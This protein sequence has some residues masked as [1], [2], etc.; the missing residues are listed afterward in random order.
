MTILP[1]LRDDLARARP[2]LPELRDGLVTARRRRRRRPVPGD[3]AWPC[4]TLLATAGALAATGVIGIGDPV[5]PALRQPRS[6]RA[7][8]GVPSDGAARLLPLRV[9]DPDGGP[10]WGLRLAPTSRGMTCLQ[11]GRVVDERLGV[12]GSDGRFHRAPAAAAATGMAP[13]VPPDG[14]G[15]FFTAVD[16]TA[17]SGGALRAPSCF[18]RGE[19]PRGSAGPARPTSRATSR[20]ACSGLRP[21]RVSFADGSSQERRRATVPTCSLRRRGK[22]DAVVAMGGGPSREP[23]VRRRSTRVDYRDGTSCPSAADQAFCP[24]KGYV[25]PRRRA[26]GS[27]HGRLDVSVGRGK[28]GPE[29][30]VSLPRAGGDHPGAGHLPARGALPGQPPEALPARDHVRADRSQ[31]GARRA[32]AADGPGRRSAAPAASSRASC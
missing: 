11:I 31:R 24:P 27:V 7:A 21:S 13:C 8:S 5:E 2:I 19:R 16:R 30:R 15:R 18:E 12:I 22:R 25:E 20:S 32:R 28:Y 3:R 26:Q 14:A 9:A 6:A 4:G 17:S 23:A 29:V 10:P 1:E